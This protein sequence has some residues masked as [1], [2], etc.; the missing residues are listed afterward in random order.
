MKKFLIV[1]LVMLTL[2][3]VGC[4]KKNEKIYINFNDG[5][6]PGSNYKIEI[7][8]KKNMKITVLNGSSLEESE[9]NEK[10][11]EVK[12]TDEQYENVK[13]VL[14][15]Y[16][17]KVNMKEKDGYSYYLDFEKNKLESPLDVQFGS[18]VLSLELIASGDA[19]AEKSGNDTLSSIV[20]NLK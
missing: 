14:D 10:V 18:F 13:K 8:N 16:S 15:F 2:T 20:K 5:L 9:I 6:T 12:L 7:D 11:V 3:V 4:G 1:V 19:S 17:K